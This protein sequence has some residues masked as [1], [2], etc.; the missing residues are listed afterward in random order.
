MRLRLWGVPAF[1]NEPTHVR[2]REGGVDELLELF[3]P[4]GTVLCPPALRTV[5]ACSALDLVLRVGLVAWVTT[6]ILI[7]T[8]LFFSFGCLVD[9][10]G[11]TGQ[12]PTRTKKSSQPCPVEKLKSSFAPGQG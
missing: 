7:S 10:V 2:N 8:Q 4:Y 5:T 12:C 1:D 11:P 3:G 6:D 9:R